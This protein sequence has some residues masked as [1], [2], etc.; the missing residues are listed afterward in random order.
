M[1]CAPGCELYINHP[2]VRGTH[3]RIHWLAG[4]LWLEACQVAPVVRVRGQIIP[5]HHLVP[6]HPELPITLGEIE[7]S[8]EPYQQFYLDVTPLG[9]SE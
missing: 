3:A 2:S 6:L 8:V 1:R 4:T 5:L 7:I 9:L